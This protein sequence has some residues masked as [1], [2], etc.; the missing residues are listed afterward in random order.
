MNTF[1]LR[2]VSAGLFLLL[3]FPSGLLLRHAGKPHNAILF[4][5]HKLIGLGMFIFLAVTVY[6]I[7]QGAP[8]ITLELSVCLL[9]GFLFLVTIVSG[10]LASLDRPIPAVISILHRLLPY[11]TAL[12]IT[13]AGFLLF[14]QR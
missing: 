2:F 13:A 8:L 1:Q 12:S 3:I 7:Q 10:G 11:L 4:N 9:S 6:R 5:L 14:Y